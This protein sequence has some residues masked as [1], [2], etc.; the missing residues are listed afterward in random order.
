MINSI[1]QDLYFNRF[2]YQLRFPKF[3]RLSHQDLRITTTIQTG[4]FYKPF[5]L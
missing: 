2:Y 3:M 1:Y 4:Y 5:V